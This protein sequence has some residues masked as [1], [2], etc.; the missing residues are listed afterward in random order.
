MSEGTII[1]I[2]FAICYGFV[3]VLLGLYMWYS[4]REMEKFWERLYGKS[5]KKRKRKK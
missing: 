5:D 1:G 3:A 4:D 2:I